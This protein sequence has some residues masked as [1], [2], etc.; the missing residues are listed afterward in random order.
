MFALTVHQPWA[1]F[2]AAGVKPV[3]NRQWSPPPALIGQWIAIH[4]GKTFDT[5]GARHI[6]SELAIDVPPEAEL[7]LGAIVAVAVLDRVAKTDHEAGY[8]EWYRG[9]FGWFLR[10]VVRI[11]P[12]VACRGYQKL[13]AVPSRE[14]V[15]LRARFREAKAKATAKAQPHGPATE[16][17]P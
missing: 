7:P 12:A 5:E 4:A 15:T 2:L 9:P 11:D 13:W 6:E 17:A 3:E 14:L 16:T 10:D 8:N 1:H